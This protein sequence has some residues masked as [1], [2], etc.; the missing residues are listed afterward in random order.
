MSPVGLFIAGIVVVILF[1][2]IVRL[3]RG[4]D[5]SIERELDWLPDSLVSARLLFAEPRAM[6]ITEPVPLTA[7]VDRAYRHPNGE[8][9]LVE[10]KTR[11][12]HVVYQSD[13]IEL[14]AQAVVL[15]AAG[16]GNV[17][18]IGYVLTQLRATGQRRVH[19]VC[20]LPREQVVAM[21]RRYVAI[22]AGSVQPKRANRRRTCGTCAF[23]TEC[24][25]SLLAL[26]STKDLLH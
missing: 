19:P 11:N 13:V 8:I 21:H 3:E 9:S 26:E 10:L 18:S 12:R 14:S 25:P 7:R 6:R 2:A 22:R 4:Q 24:M 5:G 16:H 23:Q 1:A 15:Q 20:L 17:R